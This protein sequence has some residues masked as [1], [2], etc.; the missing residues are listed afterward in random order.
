[1]SFL[2]PSPPPD[3]YPGL[4]HANFRKQSL[5]TN[6]KIGV[7][8]ESAIRLTE[9]TERSA[10]AAAFKWAGSAGTVRRLHLQT[11]PGNGKLAVLTLEAP[12]Q[13]HVEMSVSSGV[14]CTLTQIL[15]GEK[16]WE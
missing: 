7:Q 15:E 10:G 14:S 11:H 5:C 4:F 2:P 13:M 3:T 16:G 6:W 9:R 8:V 12:G 1:M